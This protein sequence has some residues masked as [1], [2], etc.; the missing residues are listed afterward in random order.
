MVAQVPQ[1]LIAM[2]Q[3]TAGEILPFVKMA[4]RFDT[5]GGCVDID[6]IARNGK[7]FLIVSDG[8]PVLGYTLEI[9]GRCVWITSAAGR[10]AV[11]LTRL[12]H[13]VI[14]AQA[15]GFECIQFETRRRG[16]VRKTQKLGYQI[17]GEIAKPGNGYIM[18]KNLK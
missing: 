12:M 16:L 4:A 17:V 1:K 9:E 18:R 14:A 5:T 6:A 8:R 13:E 2:R 3:A 15:D 7:A 10:S 11:D